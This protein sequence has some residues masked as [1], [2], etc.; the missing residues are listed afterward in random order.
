MR[1]TDIVA[2]TYKASIYCPSCVVDEIQ[3]RGDIIGAYPAGF[4]TEAWL[5]SASDIVGIDRY[6]EW[7]FDSDNFPKIIFGDQIEE[8]EYCCRCHGKI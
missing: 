4:D 7:T 6:N 3:T 1:S 5:D 2:Y 8:D